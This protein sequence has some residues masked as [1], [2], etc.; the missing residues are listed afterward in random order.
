MKFVIITG[1]SGAGKST[2]LK[3]LEDYEYFCVDNLP[4]SLIEPFAQISVDGSSSDINKLALGIDI[5]SGKMLDKMES[6]LE[7][8]T[9]M[10]IRYKI[11][12]LDS[13]DEVL[14]KRYKETRR[15]HPLA[16]VDG[17]IEDGIKLEREKTTFL[18]Q[19]ADYIIDTSQLLTREL[20]N[21][22]KQIFV[23]EHTFKNLYVSVMCFGFKYGIPTDADLVFDVR[24]LPNPYYV[25]D[26]RPLTGLDEPIK[27]FI[28]KSPE[29]DIF[30]DKFE[31]MLNFLIP[32]Y[33]QEG[34][35]QLVVAVGCTGGRHRSVM[36]AD[37]IYKR[38]SKNTDYG[39][40]ILH[41]DMQ[42]DLV[43]KQRDYEVN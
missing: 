15:T 43:T 31:D 14:V 19:R 32:H 17:R 24:F 20:R 41:R 7:N 35:N 27:Q 16:G 4:I 1:M 23:E 9:K 13:S 40:R 12:Y 29:C 37:E 6:V 39:V 5:R 2:A 18:K 42:K 21:E 22:I 38:L 30:L 3:F 33:V 36:L 8:L 10:G 26:L 34:K 11:V 25:S 28:R